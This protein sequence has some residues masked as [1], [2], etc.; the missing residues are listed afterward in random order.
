M[1]NSSSIG[2]NVEN[3]DDV[4]RDLNDLC[5]AA[6]IDL[7]F[8]IGQCVMERIFGADEQTWAREGASNRSY[9]RLAARGDLILGASALCRA[10]SIYALVQRFGGRERWSHLAASHFQEVLS[11]DFE[12]QE[13]LL[14]E[15]D[16]QRWTVSRLRAEARRLRPLDNGRPRVRSLCTLAGRLSAQFRA[17]ETARLD[18]IEDTSAETLRQSLAGLRREIDSVES[19]LSR[20][21]ART[22]SRPSEI[23][24]LKPGPRARTAE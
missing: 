6:T 23:V 11:L 22:P 18:E 4:V 5:R 19:A 1:G 13:R 17:L 14:G 2:A 9:R 8:R 7:V 24:M 10:V 21:H 12:S 15:A 20:R 3:L 16:A